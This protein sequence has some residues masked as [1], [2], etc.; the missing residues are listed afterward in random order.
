MTQGCTQS[1]TFAPARCRWSQALCTSSATPEN[2]PVSCWL[3]SC[4][5]KQQRHCFPCPSCLAEPWGE[6]TLQALWDVLGRAHLDLGW[7]LWDAPALK[8]SRPGW[9]GLPAASPSGSCPCSL[10]G[11]TFGG[12]FQ[13]KPSCPVLPSSVQVPVCLCCLCA[14]P[15]RKCPAKGRRQLSPLISLA[16]MVLI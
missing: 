13:P 6:R 1:S 3:P 16:F 5:S 14:A 11:W 9:T 4:P 8:G 12:P 7:A 2:L 15:R 10:Q